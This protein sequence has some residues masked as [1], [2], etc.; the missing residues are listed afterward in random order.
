MIICEDAPT[1]EASSWENLLPLTS[2]DPT[3]SKI[4][5]RNTKILD[6]MFQE[7][8]DEIQALHNHKQ[9]EEILLLLGLLISRGFINIPR[10]TEK[11]QLMQDNLETAINIGVKNGSIY[12]TVPK[13]LQTTNKTVSTQAKNLQIDTVRSKAKQYVT[14]LDEYTVLDNNAVRIR[15]GIKEN[16]SKV[17]EDG[18]KAGKLPQEIINDTAKAFKIS[19]GRAGTIV[20]TQ[21]MWANNSTAYNTAFGNGAQYF[22]VDYR[23]EACIKCV[24]AYAGRI[25][26][27]N[28]YNMLP[29]LHWNCVCIPR[30]F[31][32]LEEAKADAGYLINYAQTELSKLKQQNYYI[33]KDGSGPIHPDA[34]G[35]KDPKLNGR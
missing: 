28:E 20:R 21:T 27:I 10:N 26:S 2:V 3:I 5:D 33:P 32:T 22:T 13:E 6:S 16:L 18:R 15:K 29:P 11:I 35:W 34:K 9:E 31:Y 17:V 23:A 14:N 4:I 1:L 30:F 19:K 12:G 8:L 25:F 7:G 24:K